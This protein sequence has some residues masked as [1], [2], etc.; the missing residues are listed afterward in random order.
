MRIDEAIM[1]SAFVPLP[2]CEADKLSTSDD[3]IAVETNSTCTTAAA[4]PGRCR[5]LCGYWLLRGKLEVAL[6]L[7]CCVLEGE[8]KEMEESLSI[9]VNGRF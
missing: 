4:W 1:G 3:T 7:P 5:S 2:L 6:H 8:K 9:G